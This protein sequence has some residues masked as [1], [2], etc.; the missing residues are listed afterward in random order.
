MLVRVLLAGDETSI[1]IDLSAKH[2]PTISDLRD[3][4]L[5]TEKVS[6]QQRMRLIVEGRDLGNGTPESLIA[7]GIMNGSVV[8]C[9]VS[10]S[11]HAHC[12]PCPISPGAMPYNITRGSADHFN[13]GRVHQ[14]E[15]EVPETSMSTLLG[16]PPL[17]FGHDAGP[18]IE[19]VHEMAGGLSDFVSGAILGL[20]LGL[21]MLLLAT[22][23]TIA[24]SK[25]FK[26]GVRVGVLF[27]TVCGI[28]ILATDTDLLP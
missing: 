21:I 19:D 15:G 2:A 11:V 18:S 8:H 22:D 10:D 7:A 13:D 23:K 4:I 3:A 1:P 25:R 17:E 20:G 24:F 27:N 16:A 9:G 28:F 5:E 14:S 6:P 26:Y 12:V